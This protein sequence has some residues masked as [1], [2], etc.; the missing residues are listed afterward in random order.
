MEDLKVRALERRQ[1][2]QKS[3][4][5]ALQKREKT[6]FQRKVARLEYPEEETYRSLCNYSINDINRDEVHFDF[7]E[8]D[9]DELKALQIIDSTVNASDELAG[10]LS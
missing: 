6:G 3:Y 7:A 1:F 5:S 4:D 10:Q 2:F 8:Y 9:D